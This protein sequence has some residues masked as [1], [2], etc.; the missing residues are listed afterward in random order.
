MKADARERRGGPRSISTRGVAEIV[1]IISS[2][3]G[4]IGD[5]LAS[6]CVWLEPEA[7]LFFRFPFH[8]KKL[9]FFFGRLEEAEELGRLSGASGSVE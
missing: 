7:L 9:K 5:M 3:A 6:E 1:L 4:E 2:P 8:L